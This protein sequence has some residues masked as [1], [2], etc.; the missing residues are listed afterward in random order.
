MDDI[1]SIKLLKARYCRLLD[2]KDWLGLRTLFSSDV[3]IDLTG[4]GRELIVGA[5]RFM[6]FVVESVGVIV[7]VHHCHM[8]EI[9]MTGLTTANGVWAMEDLLL[10]PDGRE[11][12][13]YGHYFDAYEKVDGHWQILAS[14]LVRLRVDHKPTL[15]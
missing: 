14:R 6:S 1:E 4:F 2:T 5:E 13:G 10:Y 8:P 15:G 11:T 7:T 9:Q 3:E 12:H